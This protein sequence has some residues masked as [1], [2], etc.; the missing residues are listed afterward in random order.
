MY[1]KLLLLFCLLFATQSH[2]ASLELESNSK[3][4]MLNSYFQVD[5]F[6]N[7]QDQEVN[8]LE[9]SISFPEDL[10]QLQEIRDGNSIINFW[11]D[12]PSIVNN[13]ISFSGIIPGGYKSNNGHVLSLIFEAKRI[14]NGIIKINKAEGYKNDGMGTPI[15]LSFSNTSFFINEYVESDLPIEMEDIDKPESFTPEISQS[16]ELFDGQY[17]LVFATQDKGSGIDYYEVCEGNTK[18]CVKTESPYLLK[19]QSLNQKIYI[20]AVDKKGNERL[21]IVSPESLAFWYKDYFIYIVILLIILGMILL[22]KKLWHK[23]KK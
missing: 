23:Q 12:K 17:F 3:E 16:P 18:N 2:A 4:V 11:V 15:E 14:G 20:K 19:N 10:I 6:L 21:S 8:T 13:I 9:G 22:I 7:S 1:K 5:V